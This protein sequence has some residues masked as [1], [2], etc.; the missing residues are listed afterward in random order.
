MRRFTSQI[1][2]L[3][4]ALLLLSSMPMGIHADEGDGTKITTGRILAIMEGTPAPFSGILVSE[5]VF[6][7]YLQLEVELERER[8]RN[9]MLTQEL[10]QTQTALLLQLRECQRERDELAATLANPRWIDRP[11]TNRWIGL[12]MGIIV[13]A[14]AVKLAG[15]LD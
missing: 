10:E 15:E 3:V 5:D 1:A 2:I 12:G 8:L 6:T 11:E 9:E 7:E 13:T 14:G 4:A